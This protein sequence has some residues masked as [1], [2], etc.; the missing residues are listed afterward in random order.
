MKKIYL[1]TDYKGNFGSKHD[2]IPYRSGMNKELLIKTF[3]DYGYEAVFL[4]FSEVDFRKNWKD[5]IIIYTS[6]EDIGYHYKDY[7]EDIVYGLE[8]AGANIIPNYKYLRANNNKVFMEILRDQLEVKE[9]L[10]IKSLH[11]GSLEE[12]KNKIDKI[13]FPVVLKTAKGAMSTGVS[14]AKNKEDLKK[15][16][17]NISRTKNIRKELWDFGRS[18]KRKRYIRESKHRGK[19]IIQ[20]LIP[21]LKNDWKILIFSEKYFV[22][23]RNVRKNDFRASGS[24]QLDY[25]YGSKCSFPDGML[26]FAKKIYDAVEVP[27]ISID[28]CYDGNHFNL[29]E[30]QFVYFGSV[31]HEKSDIYYEFDGINFNAKENIESLEKFYV[32]SI[33]KYISNNNIIKNKIL[34]H[35]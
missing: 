26:Q 11:F 32:D 3:N 21:N 17:E 30:F 2:A 6:Q 4:N 20:N 23:Q 34:K 19:Y 8:L 14:L 16:V 31:G 12:L 24:G 22:F 13:D 1:L 10:T 28:L 33:T 27:N 7:I 35:E 15:K 9:G 25:H 5:K 18:L 29:I